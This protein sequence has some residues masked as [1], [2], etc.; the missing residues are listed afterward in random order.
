MNGQSVGDSDS[1]GRGFSRRSRPEHRMQLM[2]A[3]ACMLTTATQLSPPAYHMF[4][5]LRDSRR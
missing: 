4:Q 5:L 2:S 1:T 3:H